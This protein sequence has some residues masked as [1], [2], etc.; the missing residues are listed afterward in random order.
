MRAE[1]DKG[2]NL[3]PCAT[4]TINRIPLASILVLGLWCRSVPGEE[5]LTVH[6]VGEYAAVPWVAEDEEIV[7]G[8]RADRVR[9]LNFSVASINLTD[10][11]SD[12]FLEHWAEQARRGAAQGK[13]FLPRVYFWDGNDRFEGPLRDFDVYWRRIDTFLAAMPLEDFHGIVLAEENVSGG[14]R[15]EVLAELYRRIKE[16]YEVAVYQWWS[17]GGSVPTWNIPSDGWII[18]EYSVG[19]QPFRRLVQRYLVTGTPL[20]VMPYAAWSDGEADWPATT[21]Q[22]FED[23]L[24]V[25]REFNLPTAFYWVYNTGCNFGLNHGNSMDQVNDRVLDWVEEVQQLP[26]DYNGLP[27]ADHSTG[28]RLEIAPFE[29]GRLRYHDSFASSQFILDADVDGFRDLLWQS[30]QSLA[31][32][33][34]NR[35][36]PEASLTYRFEGDFP[37]HSVQ[38]SVEVAYLAPGS[39]VSLMLSVDEGQTWPHSVRT[40]GT[41]RQTL[42][43]SAAGDERFVNCRAFRVRVVMSGGPRDGTIAARIDDVDISAGLIVPEEPVIRLKACPTDSRCFS[44]VDD[45]QTQKF[46]YSANVRD[47]DKL[48]WERGSIR[49]R[50]QPGGAQPELVWKVTSPRPLREATVTVHGQANTASLGTQHYLDVSTNGQDWVQ[51]VSTAD[52]PVNNSGWA[53]HGLSVRTDDAPNFRGV[54]TFFVRLRMHAEAYKEVHPYL[55]GIVNDIRIDARTD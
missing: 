9:D 42:A 14:G 5:E 13:V 55:S 16:K 27:S 23:Q 18:D 50:M 11:L 44:Y 34:W 2:A 54:S 31:V 26:P 47:A 41:V 10:D 8:S 38:A 29:E 15:A 24:Q 49:V 37:A 7:P 39:E 40:D 51:T 53:A 36:E 43:V 30:S 20:V 1:L 21:H 6:H 52:L 33:S 25:C 3:M 32:R 22:I 46:R 19:G 28:D 45:F 48:E 35:R 4:S 12:A 17:P